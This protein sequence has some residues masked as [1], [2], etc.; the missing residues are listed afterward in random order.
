MRTRFTLALA[1]TGLALML[2]ASIVPARV[3]VEAA[4]APGAG[5]AAAGQNAASKIPD[6][7]A[8]WT[9]DPKRGGFGQSFSLSDQGG[10]KR[11]QEDDIPYLPWAR[12]KTLAEKP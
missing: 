5:Q 8:D 11:G 4:P 2:L 3:R 7:S 6:L 9:P 1:S 10:R 12:E